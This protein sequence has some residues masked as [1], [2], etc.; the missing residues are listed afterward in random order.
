M[1]D[2]RIH[3]FRRLYDRSSGKFMIDVRYSTRADVTPR[4]IGVA[5]AFGLG[6]DEAKL[7]II[8][9]NAEFQI[10]PSDIVYITGESGSGKSVL[11]RAFEKD[12]GNEA[13]NIDNLTVDPDKPLIETVGKDLN[14][15]L[16]L[17]SRVGLNDA[18]LFLRKYRE[19]SDGQRYRYRIAK[20]IES[21]KQFWIMDEFC[22]TLD[23]E[24]A[25]IV[26]FNVQ[27]QARRTGKA[28]IVATTHI[29]LL[30][31]L[32]PSVHIHKGWG[33]RL[34][35]KYYPNQINAVCSVSK[36]LRIEE[37]S[38]EDYK[39]LAEF[40]YRNVTAHPAPIKIFTLQRSDNELAGVIVYSYPPPQIF[41]RK[42]AVGRSLPIHELNEKLASISRVILHPKYR[43][44]GLGAHLVRETLPL[45]G[46]RYVETM[47]VMAQYNPFFEKAGMK[48]IAERKPDKSII[49]SIK[50]LEDLGFKSYL[51]NSQ[52]ANIKKLET[53]DEVEVQKV[54]EILLKI[55]TV[56]Y[57]R[58]R[59][60]SDIF[61][62]KDDFRKWL[63]KSSNEVLA[64]VLSRLAVLA[65]TKVYLFWESQKF[66]I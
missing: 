32:A 42:E 12:L 40:H 23:R 8:Y 61:L 6:I 60:T 27:K 35:I 15:A 43:S 56:Y 7:H 37:G 66:K 24:T 55:S 41:G 13:L 2:L 26:A 20:L 65:E 59:S 17:L 10:G 31:D 28:V 18:Y 21:G 30:E 34:E 50:S 58:L 39:A 53:L 48:R 25:K 14:E 29:D 4:T 38:M 22:A 49:Q 52:Q 11:L 33:K 45:C 46:R 9:Y 44:I 63:K 57:K 19:L 54:H 3:K 51:L 1:R 5:E 62:K 47:A 64:K 16:E 36:D